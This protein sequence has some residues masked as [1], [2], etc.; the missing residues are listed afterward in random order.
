MLTDLYVHFK[1]DVRV[2]LFKCCI[3]KVP[4]IES[5]TKWFMV[6]ITIEGL[7]NTSVTNV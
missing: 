4:E 1:L 7:V 3:D 2:Q 6:R 5:T